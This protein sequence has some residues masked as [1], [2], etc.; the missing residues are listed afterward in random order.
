MLLLVVQDLLFFLSIHDWLHPLEFLLVFQI[1]VCVEFPLNNV[2]MF[3]DFLIQVHIFFEPNY[4]KM[5]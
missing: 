1:Q 4:M 2:H 3:D 5:F